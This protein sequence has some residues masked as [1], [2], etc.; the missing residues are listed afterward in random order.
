M[1]MVV[2]ILWSFDFPDD[3]LAEVI[4]EEELWVSRK[5]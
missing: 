3:L 1:M 5:V 2:I 4:G